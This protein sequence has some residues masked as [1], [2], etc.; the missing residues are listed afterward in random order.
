MNNLQRYF[1]TQR[2]AETRKA[3]ARN[4]LRHDLDGM[5]NIL[6][7]KV[8]EAMDEIQSEYG[9]KPPCVE[10]DMINTGTIDEPD[11]FELGMVTAEVRGL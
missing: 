5:S 6:R 4:E 7:R 11:Q 8:H 1:Q 2:D 9:W 10:V 3:Q